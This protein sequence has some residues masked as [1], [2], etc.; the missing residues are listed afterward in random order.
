MT[1]PRL[2]TAGLYLLLALMGL[3]LAAQP[4]FKPGTGAVQL[5][6]TSN[7]AQVGRFENIQ[8]RC[9]A[10]FGNY[11]KTE[12]L[13]QVMPGLSRDTS[14]FSAHLTAG[15]YEIEEI[16]AG[17]SF[18]KLSDPMKKRLGTFQVEAETIS[19][20]GR[21]ILTALGDKVALGRSPTVTSNELFLTRFAAK[22]HYPATVK[23]IPGWTS[24]RDPNDRT[25]S[26]AQ[27]IPVGVEG[28]TELSDGTV[29]A[30]SRM[31]TILVRDPKKGWRSYR[32]GRLE[33]L[34]CLR[35][36]ES[37]ETLL[38]AGGEFNTLLRVDAMGNLV[39]IDPGNLPPGNI[40]YL[41]G[42]ATEGW[43]VA[44][45][46]QEA[47]TFFRSS[48]L[49]K[50]DWKATKSHPL[51]SGFWSALFKATPERF[52]FWDLPE[53]FG[54]ITTTGNAWIYDRKA[55][56]WT[57]CFRINTSPVVALAASSPTFL[58][59]V[60]ETGHQSV[61][62]RP[63]I[64]I[65]KNG[66]RFFESVDTPA[67]FR[68]LLERQDTPPRFIGAAPVQL[69][70]G[71]LITW[72]SYPVE[73]AALYRSTDNGATWKPQEQTFLQ[74]T[75]LVS[76]PKSGLFAVADGTH[77]KG[78]SVIYHSDDGGKTWKVEFSNSPRF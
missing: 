50:G 51:P 5:T 9:V 34:L 76:L 23:R 53:G 70:D 17:R 10:G 45:Q 18:L 78:E 1:F 26:L 38:I 52:W 67:D 42:N 77:S 65:S 8:V 64:N 33:S 24:P 12:V 11:G 49:E 56:K 59:L 19:D 3:P 68:M 29:V 7:T 69:A 62:G 35:A 20:L 13:K 15:T 60:L 44:H 58:T 30:A 73:R 74:G 27:L 63:G 32:T 21:V 46:G 66:G 28:M 39:P 71:T 25:E 16:T 31:G 36:V 40:L 47:M 41:D 2:K 72:C 61:R 43:V 6:F 57:E 14:L 37:A 55:V 4:A 54:Y 48:Q 22:F 75:H